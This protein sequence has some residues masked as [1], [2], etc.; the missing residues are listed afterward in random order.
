L[1]RG[2]HAFSHGAIFDAARDA[3]IVM[4]ADGLVRDWNPAAER[5]FGHGRDDVIGRELAEL[6]VPGALRDAHRNA[7]HRFV[8][9]G[10]S[11][12]LDRRL[13]LSGLRGDGSEF[14]LELTVTRIPESHPLLFAG[15]IRDLSE[16]DVTRRENARLHQRMAFLAHA[17]L[18]LDRT[19]DYNDTLQHLAELTVPELAQLTVIDLIDDDGVVRT[20]VVAASDAAQAREVERMRRDHPLGPASEHPVAE[21]LRTRRPVL[22]PAMSSSFQKKIAEGG[23]HFELMRRLR[24]HSAIVVPLVARRRALG[25]LSLLRL[26]GSTSYDQDELVLAEE[27]ARRAALAIDNARLFE[28]TR[29]IAWT[30]QESLLPRALPEIPSVRIIGRYRAA[31]EGQEVG[32]DFYDAFTI[33]PGRWGIAI[34]DVCGKGAEAAA[35]TA[36]ARYTIRALGDREPGTVLRLLGEAI[37]RD[38]H[39]YA[40]RFVTAVFARATLGS[41]GLSLEFAAGGHPPPL[42]LRANGEVAPVAVGGPLIG[43][44]ASVAYPPVSVSLAPGDTVVLYTDGLTDARAPTRMLS[45]VDVVELVARGHGLAPDQLAGFLE[46][47]ATGGESPRDD[48]ALVVVQLEQRRDADAAGSVSAN[49]PVTVGSP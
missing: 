27:L 41:D 22:L 39:A 6:V 11:T 9:T 16:R 32:G 33:A 24:Y 15:F 31:A 23:E 2:R 46:E 43:I 49:G 38:S 44:S 20:A 37:L 21:A 36:L 13:E 10:E 8:K 30:L 1:T 35:L 19:L 28:S 12:I 4:D 48:I 5:M 42:I 3:V 45:E 25:T 47:S 14:A 29:H 34:G 7:L 18:V 26:E 40:D 17:G